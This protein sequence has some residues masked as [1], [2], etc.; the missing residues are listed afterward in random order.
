MLSGV[1]W[2]AAAISAITGV[3]GGVLL[4]S[5]LILVVSPVAVV[6]LHGAVQ[7]C[8]GL[9]RLIAYRDHVQWR[10]VAPFL[11]SMVPGALVG[12]V[13]LSYLN[14][15]NPSYVLIAIALVIALSIIRKPPSENAPVVP[16]KRWSLPVL[17]LSCGLLGMF[18]G[19][20]GPLVS[21]W[22]IK[23][24]IYK[25]AHIGSKSV[26]QGSAHFIKIPLF[27][28]G[29]GFDFS[30]YL[31]ALFSMAIMVVIGTIC[32]KWLLGKVSATHFATI[33]RGLLALIVVRIVVTEVV[34]IA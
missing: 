13:G 6:P 28:W 33:V 12:M 1:A 5:G 24:G 10:V 25:E 31:G 11:I 30:P 19:S 14:T 3:A 16:P 22:L 29:L 32:G 17:G 27:I 20:T 8:A 15:L 9:S 4:L 34:K 2:L 26:M 7:F 18:V 21:S 23:N